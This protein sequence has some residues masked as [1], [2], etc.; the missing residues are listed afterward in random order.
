MDTGDVSSNII[1]ALI[2]DFGGVLVRMVDDRPRLN[3]ADQLGIPLA[4]LDD[5]VYF[6][7]SAKKA[8]VGEI[9]IKEHWEAVRKT[10]GIHPRNMAHFLELYWSADDVN[11][12]M[13]DYI[14]TLRPAYKVGLLSNAWDDLRRTLH[15]RWNIDG[16]F[17]ELVISAEVHLV[18]PDLRIFQLAVERL[19]VQ[20]AET[21]FIDDIAMNVEA[22]RIA[23]L[24]AIQFINNQ[25]TFE[26]LNQYL[27]ER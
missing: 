7:E 23:G 14:K 5:L 4:R 6:S 18:K 27:I 1:R 13:L 19:A 20:P 12:Q 25:Q 17:D 24:K 2:F 22:A 10:L 9:S 15:N 8:S 16:L 21:V 3:L 11:W 26:E